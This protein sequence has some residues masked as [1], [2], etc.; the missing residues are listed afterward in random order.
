MRRVSGQI[1]SLMLVLDD[2]VENAWRYLACVNNYIK[3]K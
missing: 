1:Q 3:N 2:I